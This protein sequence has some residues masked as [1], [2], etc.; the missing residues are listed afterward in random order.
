MYLRYA[1]IF[2]RQTAQKPIHTVLDYTHT[3]QLK[4]HHHF[5]F[6]QYTHTFLCILTRSCEHLTFVKLFPTPFLKKLWY[7]S[8]IILATL[9]DGFFQELTLSVSSSSHLTS[10]KL[11]HGS[12]V[13]GTWFC[14]HH[15][16]RNKTCAA[17]RARVSNFSF[18][19][20][21]VDGCRHVRNSIQFQFS[22]PLS[23]LVTSWTTHYR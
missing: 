18:L 7:S 1:Y 17:S 13:I 6:Y 19:V 20:D 10:T 9:P 14:S 22:D 8:H 3:Y 12:D 23:K 2:N 4:V 5:H 11:R 21:M 16:N 15:T